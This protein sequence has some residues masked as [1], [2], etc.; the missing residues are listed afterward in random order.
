MNRSGVQQLRLARREAE[1]P[2][3][4]ADHRVRLVVEQHLPADDRRVAAEPRLPEPVAEEHRAGR[5]VAI[6]GLGEQPADERLHAQRREQIGRDRRALDAQRLPGA[7]QVAGRRRGTV[8]MLSNTVL[9][10]FQSR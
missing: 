8:P 2:R 9:P 4:H 5:A 6:V 1:L 7:D 10:A 3:H